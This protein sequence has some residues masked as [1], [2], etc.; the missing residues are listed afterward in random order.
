MF[1]RNLP[2]EERERLKVT[3]DAKQ[4]RVD[5][6]REMEPWSASFE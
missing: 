1:V 2:H 3:S 6:P 4:T 5:R